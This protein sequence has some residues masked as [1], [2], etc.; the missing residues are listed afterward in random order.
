M[1]NSTGNPQPYYYKIPEDFMVPSAYFPPPEIVS[2]PDTFNTYKFDYVWYIKLF[3]SSDNGAYDLG[4]EAVTAI[5]KARNLIPIIDENGEETGEYVRL[6]DPK[7]LLLDDGACQLTV[8]WTSRR[9]Y[10]YEDYEE[11]TGWSVTY[12]GSSLYNDP[13]NESDEESED[14]DSEEESSEEADDTEE[15]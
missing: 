5:R 11:M 15:E 9:P 12:N 4:W 10:S 6:K 8:E 13:V 1:L 2:G 7:M 14:E 3:A